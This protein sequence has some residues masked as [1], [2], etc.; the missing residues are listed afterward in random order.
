[1]SD[2]QEAAQGGRRDRDGSSKSTTSAGAHGEDEIEAID[3]PRTALVPPPAASLA[4]APTSWASTPRCGWR[5]GGS[6]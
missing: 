2:T 1:M 6:S 5:W 4:A 3:G